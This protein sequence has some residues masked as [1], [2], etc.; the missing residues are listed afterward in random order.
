MAGVIRRTRWWAVVMAVAGAVMLVYF[1]GAREARAM[2]PFAIPTGLLQHPCLRGQGVSAPKAGGSGSCYY[3]AN[4][5]KSNGS[6]DP[7]P[8]PYG[9]DEPDGPTT[10][11]TGN[12]GSANVDAGDDGGGG[13]DAPGNGGVLAHSGSFSA[14]V[15]LPIGGEPFG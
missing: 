8:P 2:N 14:V 12:T 15:A 11:S 13:H 3:C 10:P 4:P 9:I 7:P 1:H 6:G 5:Q